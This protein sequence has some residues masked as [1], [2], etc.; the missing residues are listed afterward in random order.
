MYF[1]ASK[2]GV[3]GQAIYGLTLKHETID[4][5]KDKE[6]YLLVIGPRESR[7][8]VKDDES[9][10]LCPNPWARINDTKS[11]QYYLDPAL[12]IVELAFQRQGPGNTLNPGLSWHQNLLAPL[13]NTS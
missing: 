3:S 1:F 6:A 8:A 13:K 9:C 10:S 2:F 12:R 5:L 7:C 11:E 4:N